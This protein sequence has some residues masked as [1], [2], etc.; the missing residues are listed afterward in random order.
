MH[1]THL[2]YFKNTDC[3]K[4]VEEIFIKTNESKVNKAIDLLSS[5]FD[6]KTFVNSFSDKV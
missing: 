1:N 2:E 4:T 5:I 6:Q 3:K